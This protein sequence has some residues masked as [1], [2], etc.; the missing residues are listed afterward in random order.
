MKTPNVIP[1]TTR[2]ILTLAQIKAA[3]DAFEQGESNALDTL[4]AIVAAVEAYQAA[5]QSRPEAA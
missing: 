1:V 3:T 2:A 5:V 4:D